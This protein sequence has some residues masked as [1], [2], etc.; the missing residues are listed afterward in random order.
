MNGY[1][2]E[3]KQFSKLSQM[4]R[5]CARYDYATCRLQKSNGELAVISHHYIFQRNNDIRIYKHIHG[6]H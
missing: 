4:V 6:R 1:V 5:N 3:L 2:S